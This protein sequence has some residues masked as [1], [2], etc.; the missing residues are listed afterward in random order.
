MVDILGH[1]RLRQQGP[2][3][4]L[5]DSKILTMEI[6]G[7]YLPLHQDKAIFDCLRR[8]YPHFLPALGQLHRTTFVR[9][10]VHLC[11]L[12]ERCGSGCSHR[13]AASPGCNG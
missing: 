2:T 7:E 1:Q 13:Q 11:H 5:A 9:Q 6:V 8:H 10:A 4:K 3:P 12:K